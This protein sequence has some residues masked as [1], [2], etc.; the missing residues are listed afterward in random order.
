MIALAKWADQHS[1]PGDPEDAFYALSVLYMAQEIARTCGFGA[2]PIAQALR[3]TRAG[4]WKQTKN[5]LLS[6]AVRHNGGI[7]DYMRF[8]TRASSAAAVVGVVR[9][10]M[11]GFM[12]R[13]QDI[14][15]R[16]LEDVE[17]RN[18]E[19]TLLET[20]LEVSRRAA[21]R[22]LGGDGVPGRGVEGW[23][24]I[25]RGLGD[26]IGI[27]GSLKTFR[28]LAERWHHRNHELASRL[29]DVPLHL[30]W[31]PFLGEASWQEKGITF[32][33]QHSN[34]SLTELGLS[35]NH[36]VGSYASVV[37]AA[38]PEEASLIFTIEQD[39]K[40]LSTIEMGVGTIDSRQVD[41]LFC[42]I[43]Q[44]QAAG[45]TTPCKL[46]QEAASELAERLRKLPK[47]RFESYVQNVSAGVGLK[48]K[49]M[50]TIE[51]T[52]ANVTRFDLP[53]KTAEVLDPVLPKPLR[54][55]KILDL[56]MLTPD[57]MEFLLE[58]LRS[59]WEQVQSRD[60]EITSEEA[61]L[62]EESLSM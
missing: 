53:E 25:E 12:E 34:T 37:M 30:E 6:V 10:A 31:S 8:V 57:C 13:V 14:S 1:L 49:L 11:P 60:A 47:T 55:G 26:A 42:D 51:K 46:A 61:G 15:Q 40:V 39:G 24:Q 43:R 54:G 62:E 2:A 50:R 33:E 9:E 52:D 29:K 59:T 58:D 18:D 21:Q 7:G 38:T 3:Q 35:Q 16:I 36:C 27:Y 20:Y 32:R 4:E 5:A 44:N 41:R 23:S 17:I 22:A 48:A 56:A 28:E 45:N 19:A